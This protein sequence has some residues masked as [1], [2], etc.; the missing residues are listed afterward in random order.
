MRLIIINVAVFLAV[1]LVIVACFMLNINYDVILQW[2]ELPARWGTALVR[3]WTIITYQFTHI[4]L[5]HIFFNMLWLYWL[6][7]IFL[8]FF[9]TKQLTALYLLGGVCGGLL[10]LLFSSFVPEHAGAGLIGASASIYAIVVAVAYYRP[11]YQIRLLFLGSVSLKWVVAVV[12]LLDLLSINEG[13]AGGHIAHIGGILMGLAWAMAMLR[14]HD[15]TA[16]LNRLIDSTVNLVR[17]N[18]SNARW[19]ETKQKSNNNAQDDKGETKA[20]VSNNAREK[21]L[22]E[23][24]D[25][26]KK[27]GYTTL[28]DEEKEILFS[29]SRK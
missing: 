29:F 14:G 2:L 8:D 18:K 13:N 1:R 19:S 7:N 22:D 5:L 15:L 27:S 4:E 20:S 3:P 6:G 21:R 24:L 16:P 23:I 26:I 28:T 11:N 9:N 10:Y 12:V 25:K 17:R